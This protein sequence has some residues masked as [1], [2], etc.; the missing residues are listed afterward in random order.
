MR[1]IVSAVALVL[2]VS[3]PAAAFAQA[4]KP[5]VSASPSASLGGG[6]I[7]QPVGP[8]THSRASLEAQRGLVLNLDMV[9][10]A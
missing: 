8:E 10:A 4:Q 9:L 2:T 6:D 3:A 1:W 5:D 7:L